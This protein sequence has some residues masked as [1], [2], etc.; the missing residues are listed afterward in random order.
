MAAPLADRVAMSESARPET[1]DGRTVAASSKCRSRMLASM[2]LGVRNHASG[3]AVIGASSERDRI[4]DRSASAVRRT[5]PGLDQAEFCTIC[6]RVAAAWASPPGTAWAYCS[7]VVE[8]RRWSRRRETITSGTPAWSISVAMKWRRSC[9]RNGR[10][11]AARR[12]RWNALVTR[13]GFH[14]V[15]PPSSLNTNE[16]G[17]ASQPRWAAR[18][19][20]TS[21]VAGSRSTT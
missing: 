2:A 17:R 7:S 1:R 16:S 5:V 14:A 9:N 18:S 20:R 10:N 21:T 11:P 12:C 8:T 13:F 3:N 19:T 6:Q 4:A 15:A